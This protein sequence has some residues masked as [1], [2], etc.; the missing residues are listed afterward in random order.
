MPTILSKQ[1]EWTL[2]ANPEDIDLA[3]S[4]MYQS[5]GI[6]RVSLGVQSFQDRELVFLGRSQ[7][8]QRSVQAIEDLVSAGIENISIDLIFEIMNQKMDDF[9]YSVEQVQKLPITHLS[10]YDLLIEEGSFFYRKKV[11]LEK[12]R[13]DPEIAT[14]MLQG[15]VERLESFGLNRYEISAFAKEGFQSQHNTG[16]WTGREFWG[17]GPSA[18]SFIEGE[19]FQC[20]KNLKSYNT[21]LQNGQSP[22]D[23]KEKLDPILLEKELIGLRLRLIEGVAASSIGQVEI[24]KSLDRLTQQELVEKIDGFYRLTHRGRLFYDSVQLEILT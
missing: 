5:L 19:R 18:F 3:Q 20:I 9:F 15:A 2:E 23:F 1:T 8:K 4:K 12:Q 24:I 16:Y 13:P 17:I 6:N 22:Y 14:K 7:N 21:L 11:L 10:L